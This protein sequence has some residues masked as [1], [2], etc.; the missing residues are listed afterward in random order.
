LSESAADFA[1]DLRREDDGFDAVKIFACD[2]AKGAVPSA[3]KER[4]RW[5]QV[6]SKLKNP[7]WGAEM[8]ECGAEVRP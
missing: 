4:G 1:L 7:W 5:V 2:M 6:S 3:P 8:L